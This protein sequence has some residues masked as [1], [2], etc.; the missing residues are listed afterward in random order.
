MLTTSVPHP[1]LTYSPCTTQQA[2][3]QFVHHKHIQ[4]KSY[5][6]A[7]QDF[8]NMCIGW[9][10]W[11]NSDDQTWSPPHHTTPYKYYCT[12][13]SFELS[14]FDRIT[15]FA[16]HTLQRNLK[17]EMFNSW[18]KTYQSYIATTSFKKYHKYLYDLLLGL[19]STA[20]KTT[21]ILM[22]YTKEDLR[23]DRCSSQ[24]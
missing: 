4:L 1:Q 17:A 2:A 3:C 16:F 18:K 10:F 15:W 8:I 6:K 7:S 24:Q 21:Y 22:F 5:M 11:L 20:W 14:A 12:S 19:Y 23:K 9:W 13:H